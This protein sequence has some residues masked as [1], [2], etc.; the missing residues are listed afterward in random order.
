MPVMFGSVTLST[1]AIAI[2]ASTALPPRFSTSMPVC[3][4]RGWLLATIA[5]PARTTERPAGTPENHSVPATSAATPRNSRR[6]NSKLDM[7]PRAVSE[8]APRLT[9]SSD[10]VSSPVR[11]SALQLNLSR[12]NVAEF[13][14]P[15]EA[16]RFA[17]RRPLEADRSRLFPCRLRGVGR[18]VGHVADLPAVQR[19]LKPRTLE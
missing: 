5:R 14:E 19:H 6:L 17:R 16:A 15:V 3:D 10:S 4:A 11:A 12:A 9:F 18:V 8:T 7:I 1:A 13:H 2:A